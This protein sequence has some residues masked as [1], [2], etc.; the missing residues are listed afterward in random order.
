VD[1]DNPQEGI[2]S[3][4][5]NVIQFSSFYN[6]PIGPPPQLQSPLGDPTLTLPVTLTWAHV[7]NPQPMGY[8]LQIARDA[9]F[10]NIEWSF[11]Q[12]TEPSQEMLSLTSGPKFWR[13]LSQHGL[14]SPT[15][16]ANTDWSTTGRF[17]ISSA[18]ATPVSIAVRGTPGFEYSGAE[19]RVAL[20][21]TA[22][23]PAGG[24]VVA[25]TSSHPALAP[26]PATLD[27][28]RVRLVG[29]P[30]HVRPSDFSDSRDAHRQ[31]ER[32]L[33]VEPVHPAPAHAERRDLPASS[34]ARPARRCS[35]GSI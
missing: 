19:R 13:V 33:R 32:R 14:S 2:R 10:S 15:T 18:P 17:T 3:L 1:A 34:Y 9:G 16:N 30:D 25:L 5:S 4:P 27:A 31:A 29:D 12:Y 23:A 24:A 11:N 26:L 20:Q 7:P 28:G 21:L 35:D 6:N 22:G 8:V